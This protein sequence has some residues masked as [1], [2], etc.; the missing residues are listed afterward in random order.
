MFTTTRLLQGRTTYAVLCKSPCC[1][2]HTPDAFLQQLID[3]FTTS[4][5]TVTDRVVK[6][7]ANDSL[8]SGFWELR[9]QIDEV[10]TQMAIRACHWELHWQPPPHAPACLEVL[11]LNIDRCTKNAFFLMPPHGRMIVIP[12]DLEDAFATDDRH[13]DRV[14]GASGSDVCQASCAHR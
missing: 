5:A 4:L 1:A 9:V 11:I 13:G 7:G 6:F 14:C 8:V 2:L 10:L 12:T 3:S